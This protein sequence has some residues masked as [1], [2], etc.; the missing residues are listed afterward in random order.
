MAKRALFLTPA[1]RN[2]RV[3]ILMKQHNWT[4]YR[5]SKEMNVCQTHVTSA[6]TTSG[7][8]SLKMVKAAARALGVSAGF[9]IDNGVKR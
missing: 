8:P 3:K 7:E 4:W 6:F 2:R 5:L 9:L 1:Q